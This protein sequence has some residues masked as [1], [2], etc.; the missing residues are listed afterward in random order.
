VGHVETDL[1]S[2]EGL[3]IIDGGSATIGIESTVIKLKD[4][5]VC[6]LRPGF[7]T[8]GDLRSVLGIQFESFAS[9]KEKQASPGQETKH[10]APNVKTVLA[11]VGGSKCE[12]LPTNAVIVDFNRRFASISGRALRYLDLSP[13]GSVSEA[14]SRVYELLR[15]VESVVGVDICVICDVIEEEIADEH[16]RELVGSLRDR[17]LRSASH[18]VVEYR[19]SE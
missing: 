10:Y 18:M 12:I 9:E 6:I 16:E 4:D 17:L 7:V 19:L 3:L 15:E 2:T 11:R 5:K 14:I 8:S 1:G 13:T